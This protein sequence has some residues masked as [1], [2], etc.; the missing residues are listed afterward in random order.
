M[1]ALYPAVQRDAVATVP[2]L[3]RSRGLGAMT[4]I[5]ALNFTKNHIKIN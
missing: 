2:R 1:S 5:Y 4:V 3:S